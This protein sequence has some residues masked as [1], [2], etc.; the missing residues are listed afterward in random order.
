MEEIIC[1]FLA[2][3]FPCAKT[4]F[5][6]KNKNAEWKTKVKL[7]HKSNVVCRKFHIIPPSQI[8]CGGTPAFGR[9]GSLG[10]AFPIFGVFYFLF[11]VSTTARSEKEKMPSAVPRLPL[12]C[13]SIACRCGGIPLSPP[14]AIYQRSWQ[15]SLIPLSRV[16][17]L[18]SP[19]RGKTRN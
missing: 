12:I 15:A 6:L 9:E 17:P 3:P 10:G 18:A 14:P 4:F 2:P 11:T 1:S 19:S 8:I 16:P 7:K 13:F 5:S